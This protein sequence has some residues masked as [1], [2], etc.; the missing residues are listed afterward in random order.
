MHR[1]KA[2]G[3]IFSRFLKER[4]TR[5]NGLPSGTAHH[6]L[7]ISFD[8]RRKDTRWLA[9]ICDANADKSLLID[10]RY[11]KKKP[12]MII[13]E[14]F[15]MQWKPNWWAGSTGADPQTYPIDDLGV[16]ESD[17]LQGNDCPMC[18]NVQGANIPSVC[19]CIASPRV[20]PRL[21][22]FRKPS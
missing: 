10:F 9:A 7:R 15:R 6:S 8:L 13:H 2:F 16:P 20:P 3:K 12:R 5:L 1:A 18:C 21:N 14:D 4:Q 19:H 22:S 11:S 17:I